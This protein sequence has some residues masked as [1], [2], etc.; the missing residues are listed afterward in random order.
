[1]I[2]GWARPGRVRQKKLGLKVAIA[3]TP[4]KPGTEGVIE[5]QAGQKKPGLKVGA[6]V[7]PRKSKPSRPGHLTSRSRTVRTGVSGSYSMLTNAAMKLKKK[8]RLVA[9]RTSS[10][11]FEFSGHVACSTHKPFWFSW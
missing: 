9:G 11:A 3:V 5:G 4:K 7:T 8:S 1:M 2:A 10:A 6:A